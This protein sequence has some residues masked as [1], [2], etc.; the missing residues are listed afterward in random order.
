MVDNFLQQL[1]KTLDQGSESLK[2]KLYELIQEVLATEVAETHDTFHSDSRGFTPGHGHKRKGSLAS[3]TLPP[4]PID[5]DIPLRYSPQQ[6]SEE[7]SKHKS[8]CPI[9]LPD[10][11]IPMTEVRLMYIASSIAIRT[12]SY[13]R[14]YVAI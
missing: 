1:P 6:V 12:Y 7:N 14:S 11:D 10:K 9:V 13:I 4:T 2:E 5:F 8:D 3:C